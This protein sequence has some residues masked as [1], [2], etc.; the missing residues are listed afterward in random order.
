MD[1]EAWRLLGEERLGTLAWRALEEDFLAVS[2]PHHLTLEDREMYEAVRA[3]GEGLWRMSGAWRLACRSTLWHILEEGKAETAEEMPTQDH[4]AWAEGQDESAEEMSTE[5]YAFY[6]A[7]DEVI[8][9]VPTDG[10]SLL[11]QAAMLG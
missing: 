6:E 7:D 9:D 2:E 10:S 4:A 1:P 8:E 3:T 11:W 5:D